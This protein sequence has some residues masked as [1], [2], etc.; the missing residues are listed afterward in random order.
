MSCAQVV[1]GVQILRTQV[2]M[3][4][5]SAK[6]NEV[7]RNW[8]LV[9]ATG[10]TLGRMATEIASRLKGKHKAEFT[11]HADTGDYVVVINA[12]KVK[13]T[14]NKAKDK[15]YHSHSGYPGGLKSIS[16]E[17]LQDKAPEKIIQLAVKGM[18]P[19]TPLGRSMLKKLKVYAGASH[20]HSAQ[21]PQSVQI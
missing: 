18:L 14:G 6:T 21:Q 9:D 5:Y 20:P 3:K 4:T 1:C 12:E 15:Y 7:S 19:R 16:F 11:P 10:K 17:K 13:V 8:L 2:K